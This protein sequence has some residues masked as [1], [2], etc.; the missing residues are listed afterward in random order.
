M[1]IFIHLNKE[2]CPAAVLPTTAALLSCCH[3]CCRKASALLPPSPPRCRHLRRR[4]VA[5]ATV[6]ALMPP[7]RFRCRRHLCFYR[8]RSCR[9]RSVLPP[10]RYCCRH[11]A[12]AVLSPPP[13]CRT[14]ATTLPLT[15]A[16]KL[17]PRAV[18][19]TTFV[20]IVVVTVATA[21]LRC[22]CWVVSGGHFNVWGEKGRERPRRSKYVEPPTLVENSIKGEGGKL[23]QQRIGHTPMRGIKPFCSTP[24]AGLSSRR[25]PTYSNLTSIALPKLAGRNLDLELQKNGS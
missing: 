16:A 15:A 18:A 6:T 8:H 19:T 11:P 13:F 3:R 17:P 21:L 25:L 5:N 7:P 23:S 2:E 12:A 1:A 22:Q 24:L 9:R 4:A 10:P 14:A 20:F